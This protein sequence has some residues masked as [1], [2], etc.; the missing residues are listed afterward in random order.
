MWS[1]SVMPA[2]EIKARKLQILFIVAQANKA[3]L[4]GYFPKLSFWSYWNKQTHT[5]EKIL[6]NQEDI[7]I[8][9]LFIVW[10]ANFLWQISELIFDLLGLLDAIQLK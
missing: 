8:S 6:S 5:K 9:R 2:E 4:F 10:T 3:D 1:L 7:T